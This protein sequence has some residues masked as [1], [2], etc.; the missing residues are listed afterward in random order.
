M[1]ESILGREKALKLER[2]LGT[3]KWE[4]DNKEFLKM[5]GR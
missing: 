2:V 4:S 1:N 5:K 3:E